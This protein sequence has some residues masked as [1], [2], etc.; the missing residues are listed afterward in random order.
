MGSI[1]KCGKCGEEGHAKKVGASMHRCSC[2]EGL[3]ITKEELNQ[4]FA[5][6]EWLGFNYQDYLDFISQAIAKDPFDLVRAKTTDEIIAGKLNSV[7]VDELRNVLESGFKKGQSLREIAKKVEERVKPK[8][9]FATKEGRLVL[10]DK[11]DK[12]LRL[13]A[14]F[15]SI[16]LARSET[17]RLAAIGAQDNYKQSGIEQYSWIA[18]IGSRTCPTCEDLN[19]QIFEIGRGEMP[20]AHGMCRCTIVPIV[21]E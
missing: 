20:P 16:A 14:Q 13:S 11:G 21:K 4:D 6:Q 15:R 2:C 19:G 17:T 10:N 18:S 1:I 3:N 8:D 5:L 7:K 9:L 12:I